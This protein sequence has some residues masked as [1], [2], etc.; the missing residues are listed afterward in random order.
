MVDHKDDRIAQVEHLAGQEKEMHSG[1]SGDSI[2]G[3]VPLAEQPAVKGGVRG[4]QPPEF[5]RH[6]T[7]EQRLELENKLKRKIDLR[8]MP[9]VILMYILN[10]IDRYVRPDRYPWLSIAPREE[11]GR[12]P[13]TDGVLLLT[14]VRRAGTISRR[15]GWPGWRET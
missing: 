15:H 9:C 4:L 8:L 2:K 13:V 14:R 5:L 12:T 3:D 11:E 6:M 1:A 10:Y 7:M